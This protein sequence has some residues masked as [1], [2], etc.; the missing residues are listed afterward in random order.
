MA[1][2][3]SNVTPPAPP[4]PPN[5]STGDRSKAY[6][7]RAKL[8]AGGIL[9]P[10]EEEWLRDY[11]A[12]RRAKGAAAG[13]PDFGVAASEEVTHT[14]KRQIAMG[15]GDA[16]AHAVAAGAMVRE[17]GK[18]LDTLI[19][20]ATA[21]MS[22]GMTAMQR[23]CELHEAMAEN[24]L[25]DRIADRAEMRTLM[26]SIRE[27]YLARIS[28]EGAAAAEAAKS[29]NEGDPMTQVLQMVQ[30]LR[31]LS[32]GGPRVVPGSGKTGGGAAG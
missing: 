27:H 16:A 5:A 25:A 7:L 26:A 29:A 10:S 9:M 23:A 24:I 1:K 4:S 19:A 21:A 31:A 13:G 15:T 20:Q 17:E 30:E 18:R 12:R 32:G 14:E 28:A 3:P 2:P 8:A 6:K 22:A 11:E